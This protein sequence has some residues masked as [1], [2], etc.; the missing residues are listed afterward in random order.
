MNIII[1]FVIITKYRYKC[2][3]IFALK[4]KQSVKLA[5][6]LNRCIESLV[7]KPC[8]NSRSS[9]LNFALPSAWSRS[10]K[11]RPTLPPGNL[12]LPADIISGILELVLHA[13]AFHDSTT[14]SSLHFYHHHS[15][16]LYFYS[17]FYFITLFN[18]LAL[19]Y[20]Y[21]TPLIWIKKKNIP[22]NIFNTIEH[23]SLSVNFAHLAKF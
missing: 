6:A 23:P 15:I 11:A 10:D 14:F 5:V 4:R 3:H 20:F 17:A 1:V 12:W 13:E 21:L 22:A 2:I 18:S 9:L 19:F 8:V 7:W 16:F